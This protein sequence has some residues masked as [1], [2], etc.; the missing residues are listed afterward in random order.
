[1]GRLNHNR[2]ILQ[3]MDAKKQG[4][5][6][7][8]LSTAALGRRYLTPSDLKQDKGDTKGTTSRRS[9]ERVRI[10]QAAMAI[11]ERFRQH[12]D[13]RIVSQ[14]IDSVEKQEDKDALR[15]WFLRFGGMVVDLKSGGFRK[16]RA[17]APDLK[18][19]AAKPYWKFKF[20]Y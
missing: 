12:G 16:N 5:H 8:D 14:M 15:T 3:L 20:R 19:G 4:K 18:A 17:S 9:P 1:M 11:V 6:V 10:H 2:P 13:T 7:E